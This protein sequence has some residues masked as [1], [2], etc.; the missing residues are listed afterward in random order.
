MTAATD[1]CVNTQ[2]NL[3][4][5]TVPLGSKASLITVTI[6]LLMK[7]PSVSRAAS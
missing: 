3:L 7:Y 2:V 1:E 4:H 5:M 6:P